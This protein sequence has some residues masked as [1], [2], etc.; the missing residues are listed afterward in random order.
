[1]N[2]IIFIILCTYND[3]WRSKV[4]Y[5][6]YTVD[7]YLKNNYYFW[8]N[9]IKRESNPLDLVRMMI[10]PLFWKMMGTIIYDSPVYTAQTQQVTILMEILFGK[11]TQTITCFDISV[12]TFGQNWITNQV[13]LISNWNCALKGMYPCYCHNFALSCSIFV[14][15]THFSDRL[16]NPVCICVLC[17]EQHNPIGTRPTWCLAKLKNYSILNIPCLF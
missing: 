10:T 1:M 4:K 5:N 17:T 3:E 8:Q 9:K 13:Q 6:M 7:Q 2:Q 15:L 12:F 14:H 16:W 11:T